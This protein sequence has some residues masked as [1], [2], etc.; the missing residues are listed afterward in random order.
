MT[1]VFDGLNYVEGGDFWTVELP[2]YQQPISLII[3]VPLAR[4]ETALL[5]LERQLHAYWRASQG[6]IVGGEGGSGVQVTL[7]MPVFRIGM[8]HQ[9]AR[10]LSLLG[11]HQMFGAGADF[12][13][14]SDEPG[15]HI[16]AI[17]QNTFISVDQHGTEAAAATM[18]VML[19]ATRPRKKVTRIIDRPFL[20]AIVDKPSDVI[21]FLGKIVNPTQENP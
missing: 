21:L 17:V 19:G 4:G 16:D 2:Y 7:T 3:I 13:G 15:L 8:Q 12:S 5:T 14:V 6:M 18:P 20:F 9:L 11:L 10:S 1:C